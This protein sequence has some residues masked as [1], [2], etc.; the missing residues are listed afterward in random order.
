MVDRT[1]IEDAVIKSTATVSK[2]APESLSVDTHF[3]LDLQF[4]SV[5]A[6]KLTVLLEDE[7][8]IKMPMARVLKNQTL[9]DLVDL[10]EELVAAE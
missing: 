3:A 10:V 7:F 8:G 6:M 4:R 2:V 1:T 5:Q 9:R